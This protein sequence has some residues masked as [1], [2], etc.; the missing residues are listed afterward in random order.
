MHAQICG[1]FSVPPHLRRRSPL[2]GSSYMSLA[3]LHN[4]ITLLFLLP[5]AIE[6]AICCYVST[7]RALTQLTLTHQQQFGI[8]SAQQLFS[9]GGFSSRFLSKLTTGGRSQSPPS[10]GV[11]FAHPQHYISSGSNGHTLITD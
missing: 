2:F 5:L 8:G 11:N 1:R 10:V 7:C 3:P 9:A 6:Q 4:N